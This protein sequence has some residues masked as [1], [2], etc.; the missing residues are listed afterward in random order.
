M[1]Y[2]LT[3]EIHK[4]KIWSTCD[5]RNCTCGFASKVIYSLLV[6]VNIVKVK[7]KFGFPED[8]D[9]ICVYLISALY[10]FSF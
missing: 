9:K 4:Q 8:N 6:Y 7:F 2:H 10:N 3:I 5:I 1:V